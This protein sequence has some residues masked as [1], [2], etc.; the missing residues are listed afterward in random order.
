MPFDPVSYAMGQKSAGG[1]GGGGGSLPAY[2]ADDTGKVLTVVSQPSGRTQTLF[3]E[4]TITVVDGEDTVV[5]NADLSLFVVG[6]P[7]SCVVD[8]DTYTTTV[9]TDGNTIFAE[10]SLG[11]LYEFTDESTGDMA[12]G[13]WA[14]PGTY[15]VSASVAVMEPSATWQAPSGITFVDLQSSY[16]SVTDVS[17]SAAQAWAIKDNSLL[18][19]RD[20]W[21]FLYPYNVIDSSRYSD[22]DP[23]GHLYSFLAYGAVPDSGGHYANGYFVDLFLEDDTQTAYWVVAKNW[24][25]RSTG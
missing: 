1:G 5:S 15:T 22:N 7:I 16:G 6:A 19:I 21:T 8:G 3:P 25:G 13:F 12:L 24:A 17:I 11:S 10:F 2:T 23:V 9:D 18:V 14:D 20:G 4:Q